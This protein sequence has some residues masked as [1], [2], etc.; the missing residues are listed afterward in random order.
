MVP[1]IDWLHGPAIDNIP[2]IVTDFLVY[3]PER[4]LGLHGSNREKGIPQ[5]REGELANREYESASHGCARMTNI[6]VVDLA[7][8]YYEGM[9]I[10]ITSA[11]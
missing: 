6:D 4:G 5:D 9:P 7:Q 3:D 10:Y 1:D 11:G 8:Y 2:T